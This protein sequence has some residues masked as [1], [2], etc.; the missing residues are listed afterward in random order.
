ME[1][2]SSSREKA[3]M[4]SSVVID[5]KSEAA[6]FSRVVDR[7]LSHFSTETARSILDL[8]FGEEDHARIDELTTRNQDGALSVEEKE[9]LMNYVKVGNLLALFQSKAR[10]FLKDQGSN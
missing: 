6:I 3:R 2:H 7:S 5:R 1:V 9:E 10:T 4:E 8:G